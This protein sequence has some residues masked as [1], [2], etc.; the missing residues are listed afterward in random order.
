MRTTVLTV[1]ASVALALPGPAFAKEVSAMKVCGRDD[2]ITLKNR[3]LL[4]PI[5][6]SGGRPAA[7][8]RPAPFYRVTFQVSEPGHGL[9]GGW[10]T[11]YV[12]SP[13]LFQGRDEA[14]TPY[15]YA[16]NANTL[17]YLRGRLATVKPYP[18]PRFTRVELGTTS[19]REPMSYAALFDPKFARTD[20]YADDWK[21]VTIT[22]TANPWTADVL[23]SYSPDK[24]VLWRGRERVRLPDRLAANLESGRSALASAPDRRSPWRWIGG[25]VAALVL[26]GGAFGLLRGRS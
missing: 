3:S 1:S 7:T 18:A 11:W 25:T 23:L 2:C 4:T 15:W 24:N 22:A 8:P 10:D 12:P 21:P 16:P 17:A 5:I 20:E 19:V 6:E 14:N 26:G 9:V 13:S